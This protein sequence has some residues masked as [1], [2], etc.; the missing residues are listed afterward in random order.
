[1]NKRKAKAEKAGTVRHSAA[2]AS[3][4]QTSTQAPASDRPP[5]QLDAVRS[6]LNRAW[7]ALLR[8]CPW[9]LLAH[10]TFA[11]PV[12][13][14]QGAKRFA[15]WIAALEHHPSRH[16][17]GRIIWARGAEDQDRGALHYHGLLAG[18]TGIAPFAAMKLW[19]RIGGGSA[20]IV[21]YDAAQRGAFYISKKGDVDISHAWFGDA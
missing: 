20:R 17:R 13:P 19:E 8:P 15:R 18:T 12:H 5:Y 6:E 11:T 10:L 3:T 9:T 14:E 21:P 1:M 16:E 2:S 4:V 7:D